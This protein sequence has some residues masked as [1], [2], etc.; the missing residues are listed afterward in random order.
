M[1]DAAGPFGPEVRYRRN[2]CVEEFWFTPVPGR[3]EV[4]AGEVGPA[5]ARAVVFQAR[6]AA[7]GGTLAV[8]ASVREGRDMAAEM[9]GRVLAHGA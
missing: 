1:A 8:Q 4:P 7:P 9:P 3:G 2:A 5:R 6:Y